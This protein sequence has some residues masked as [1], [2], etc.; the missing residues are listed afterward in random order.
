MCLAT[1]FFPFLN[2]SVKYL[3]RGYPITEV[4]FARY[5]GHSLVCL[6]LFLPR[7][8]SALFATSRPAIH[9]G[10]AFLLFIASA[11]YFIGI[12]SID[13][14]TAAAIS[15]AGPIFVTALSVPLLGEK[16][17]VRRWTAVFCGFLGALIIIRPG[18]AVIQWGAALVLVDALAYGLYQILSRKIGSVDPAY[19]SITLSGIG[20]LLISCLLLPFFPFRLPDNAADIAVFAAIGVWGLLGH[21]FV[22]KA[23]QWGRAS[24]VAPVGYVELVGATL[25]G[26]FLFGQFPDAWTWLG[27]A[28]IVG[29]GLYI[30]LREHR[31]Q[32][33]QRGE[34]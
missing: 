16:V 18:T 31:L 32:R 25:V 20:G 2:A 21:Y 5:L 33:R 4:F 23:V 9:A 12:Q 14:S 27:A 10:R 3:G 17:G 28:I 29:S 1:V 24:V 13:L 30:T 7:H 19:T 8:G 15:F 6:A 26:W 34:A 22:I 11:F